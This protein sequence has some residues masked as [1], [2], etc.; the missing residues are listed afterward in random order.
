VANRNGLRGF[1]LLL[2]S[3]A[4]DFDLGYI[5]ER[6]VEL[7]IELD[8]F[9]ATSDTSEEVPSAVR[10]SWSFTYAEIAPS[11]LPDS[12]RSSASL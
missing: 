5:G 8:D 9:E 11:R 6:I 12:T 10:I 3:Q 4:L 2:F 7:G 1:A